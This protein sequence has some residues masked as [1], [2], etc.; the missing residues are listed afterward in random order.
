MKK[1]LILGVLGMAGH[2]MAEVFNKNDYKVYGVAR[3]KGNYVDKVLDVS[4]LQQLE[5]YI[6]SIKPEYVINC[7]GVLVSQSDKDLSTA[8][9]I[10]SYLPNYLSQLGNKIG[11]KLIHISTDCVFSGRCGSYKENSFC[12]GNDNYARSKALGEVINDKDLTIRTS[13]I[14]PEIKL[15]NTSGLLDWF[16]NQKSDIKGYRNAYWSGVTTLELASAT[17]EFIRQDISGLYHLCPTYK[18]SKY[19]LL[20][21]F[22]EIWNKNISIAPYDNYHIDKS[23]ICTRDDFDYEVPDYKSM[24]IS[25]KDWMNK[26]ANIYQH[27]N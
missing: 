6:D 15:N 27:Y 23:L 4:D 20:K 24:L 10:N 2:I 22:A 13:I 11:F 14:G 1:V 18:I 8:I 5:L 25:L 17:L 3:Q 12:D 9:L 21:L 16:L 26:Y 19:N 7:I